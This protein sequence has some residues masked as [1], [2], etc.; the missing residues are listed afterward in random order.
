[1]INRLKVTK[2]CPQNERCKEA[3]SSDDEAKCTVCQYEL[4]VE[5]SVIALSCGH[6]FHADC[7]KKWLELSKMCPICNEEYCEPAAK[8][9]KPA[10]VSVDLVDS[11]KA[12]DQS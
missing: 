5:D 9:S 8:E 7:I 4:E 2:W 11:A 3:N 6:V 10:V 1:M 12:I